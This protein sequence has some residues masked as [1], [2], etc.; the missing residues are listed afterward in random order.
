MTRLVNPI[1]CFNPSRF[2]MAQNIFKLRKIFPGLKYH[3]VMLVEE[4]RLD[5]IP[6]YVSGLSTLA[7]RALKEC[8]GEDVKRIYPDL[9]AVV[10]R[11]ER[12]KHKQYTYYPDLRILK[13]SVDPMASVRKKYSPA[14]LPSIRA[15]SKKNLIEIL[16]KHLHS[17][18]GKIY[19]PEWAPDDP[20]FLLKIAGFIPYERDVTGKRSF[21]DEWMIGRFHT[22]D[23]DIRG[24]IKKY[25]YADAEETVKGIKTRVEDCARRFGHNEFISKI[26]NSYNFSFKEKGI[27]YLLLD[28]ILYADKRKDY[29]LFNKVVNYFEASLPNEPKIK[30]MIF[31]M[32]IAFSR[33]IRIGSAQEVYS[34]EIEPIVIKALEDARDWPVKRPGFVKIKHYIRGTKKRKRRFSTV[35]IDGISFLLKIKLNK[36]YKYKGLFARRISS[37]FAGIYYLKLREDKT[38]EKATLLS[39]F[40]LPEDKTS[41]YITDKDLIPVD[42]IELSDSRLEKLINSPIFLMP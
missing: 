21:V 14:V 26:L 32:L 42:E 35:V 27:I 2:P 7:T 18:R 16:K 29:M 38:I 6:I 40:P 33:K 4:P 24:K 8:I 20:D 5:T 28:I 13:V 1:K 36:K 25:E 3:G 10:I 22:I 15:T 37:D 30:R 19:V 23:I 9:I 41:V 17:Q 31:N 34:Q 12:T 39:L 11:G